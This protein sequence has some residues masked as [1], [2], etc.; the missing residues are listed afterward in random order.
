MEIEVN[1]NKLTAG[2]EAT[3][4]SILEETGAKKDR[5]AVMVN[6]EI[7]HRSSFDSRTLAD[8]DRIDVMVL[9]AGG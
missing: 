9:A 4:S 3:V 1:G 5:V 2:D 6:G 8:G 7:I